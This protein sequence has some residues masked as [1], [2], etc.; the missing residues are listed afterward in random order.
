V[1]WSVDLHKKTRRPV[2]AGTAIFVQPRFDL[3]AYFPSVPRGKTGPVCWTLR[4]QNTAT[5]PVQNT[6]VGSMFEGTPEIV[7]WGIT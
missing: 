2:A 1:T 6:G 5:K 4:L 7:I 3:Q